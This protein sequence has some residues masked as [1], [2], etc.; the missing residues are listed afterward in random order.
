[1]PTLRNTV[2]R[3]L[4]GCALLAMVAA[5]PGAAQP[6]G[7]PES[8][9]FVEQIAVNVVNVEVYVRDR[10]GNPVPGLG[11]EDFEV[12]E[13]GRPVE[14]VNFYLV[15]GGVPGGATPIPAAGNPA[16]GQAPPPSAPEP[17]PANPQPARPAEPAEP[18]EPPTL[19][20]EVPESQ[21]LHLIVYVDNYN[22]HPLNRNRV[23]AR[24]RTFLRETLVH[25]DE[26]MLAS[27]DRSLQ[28]RHPF[29]GDAEAV[30]RAL[31]D[32]E[33]VSGMG[34]ERES[35]RAQAVKTIYETK[36][37]QEAIW[38]AQRF[39]EN[40]EHEL[41][42][43]LDALGEMLESLAGLPGRKML[44]HVSDGLALVPGQDLYQAIQQ[45][46][47]DRSALSLAHARD[48]SRKY[49]ALIARANTDRITFYTIDASGLSTRAMGAEHESIN[50]PLTVSSSVG[51]VR[52]RN[53]Q[54]SLE[55][56]ADRTGGRAILNTNDVA[57]GLSRIGTDLG[58]Y[59]SLGYRAPTIDRGRYHRIEVRLKSPAKGWRLRHREGYRDKSAEARIHD[60]VQAFLVHGYQSNPLA[61]TL[62]AGPQSAPQADGFVDV[63]VRV[64]VPIEKVTLIPRSDHHQGRVKLYFSALDEEG[65]DAPLQELPFELRIPNSSVGAARTDSMV[66][67][68]RLTMRPG[69]HK[70][71]VVVRDE[72]SDE[73]SVVGRWLDV[74]P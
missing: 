47:A 74:G 37:V 50:S 52:A 45:R 40:Q 65:R 32:L 41:G 15:E 30:N 51:A 35:E 12:L 56:L 7:Q 14:V 39:A 17:T 54:G 21:R 73:R 16:E 71:V 64:S 43:A 57:A 1:M 49:L 29:T 4:Y 58:H 27:Y 10:E 28:I 59:Y 5:A 6:D 25:G 46:F 34:L 60:G 24:L 11:P 42:R 23:F 63:T 38:A 44:L 62:E 68:I 61:V 20:A 70:V 2:R 13:D 66:R 9:P 3:M 31:L 36:A 48:A 53:L 69:V 19:R 18:A 26:L 67:D 72:L 22:I 8:G 55:L 33:K